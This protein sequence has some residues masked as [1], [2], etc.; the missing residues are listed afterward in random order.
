M[1]Q[2]ILWGNMGVYPINT[3]TPQNSPGLENPVRASMVGTR[4]GACFFCV[5]FSL[6]IREGEIVSLSCQSKPTIN[7]I[8]HPPHSQSQRSL[9]FPAWSTTPP[10]I[11]VIIGGHQWRI[12]R[13][14][15]ASMTHTVVCLPRSSN[16]LLLPLIS[17]KQN[18][19]EADFGERINRDLCLTVC[20]GVWL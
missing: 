13:V 12:R 20:F 9:T 11:A 19:S 1:W 18:C 8:C 2:I 10:C 17:R 4:Q 15:K 3:S 5:F 14:W 6:S 16:S 7:C